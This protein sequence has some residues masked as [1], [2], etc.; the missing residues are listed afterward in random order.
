MWSQVFTVLLTSHPGAASLSNEQHR[1]LA[2]ITP[3]TL[4]PDIAVL[5]VTSQAA[6]EVVEKSLSEAIADGFATV[7]GQRCAIVV[8]VHTAAATPPQR[9]GAPTDA[10]GGDHPASTSGT[11]AATGVT[12]AAA[13]GEEHSPVESGT[14]VTPETKPADA[15]AAS[16]TDDAAAMNYPLTNLIN[17][18]N[19]A[20]ASGDTAKE[21][22][23]REK[24]A[25]AEAAL[26]SGK[27]PIVDF[28][29]IYKRPPGAF[30]DPAVEAEAA[31]VTSPIR[32]QPGWEKP[33]NTTTE[34]PAADPHTPLT[35]PVPAPAAAAPSTAGARLPRETATRSGEGML[36]PDDRYTFD[37]FVKG[38][39]NNFTCAAAI[40]VAEQPATTYNPLFIYGPS[41][42]GKTHLL[43]ATGTYAKSLN[44]KL[45]IKYVSSE[46][47]TNDYINSTRDDRQE[48]FKRR[49]R[50]LDILM[51]DDIQFLAGKE[52][53]Q[54][55]FFHTFNSLFLADKQIILTSDRGPKELTTLH[56]RLVTRFQQ[57]LITDIQPPDL[58]TRIAILSKKAQLEHIHVTRDVLE[59]I[60]QHFKSSIRE[61]EGALIR[62][63][64]AASLN[65]EPLT[66]DSAKHALSHILPDEADM[67]ITPEVILEVAAEYFNLSTDELTGPG[68]TKRVT[69]PRQLAMYLCRELTDLSLP[70]I[71]RAFGGR[72]HT[73]V[74]Y[75][76]QK[77]REKL[78][79]NR[80][81]LDEIQQLTQQIKQQ[82]R[83]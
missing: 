72:D 83:G 20:A 59:F 53:T 39:S 1:A 66:V 21:T 10:T 43:R 23:L 79:A 35:Q 13:A 40:A 48:S 9:G 7:T 58:E 81:T 2:D 19:Q 22:Q 6:K 67:Q 57:G 47:F 65:N 46:E 14:D 24:L 8:S 5:Q 62:V 50:E 55:E 73:T 71:G 76:D 30:A 64:A 69:H 80:D 75:A 36:K 34:P 12:G 15:Q 37:T 18:V 60:A 4:L 26:A 42:L 3:V 61:L 45:R 52:L 63:S 56:D 33:T 29:K 17:E 54:E 31:T 27:L 77:I 38:P 74:M 16:T 25:E 51:V 28:L 78:A 41:G 70:S 82:A 11:P 49:Y 32:P 44:P 68:R